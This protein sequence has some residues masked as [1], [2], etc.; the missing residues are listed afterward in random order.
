MLLL[1][2]EALVVVLTLFAARRRSIDR[3]MRARL[4][5]TFSMFGPPLR[6]AGAV[7]ALAPE[8]LTVAISAA[9]LVD[10]DRRERCRSAAASA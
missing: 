6:A 8:A 3:S 10:R 2:S 7:A 5:T 9:G 4:L 1:A